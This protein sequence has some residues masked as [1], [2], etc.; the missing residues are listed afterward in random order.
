M[1]KLKC[2]NQAALTIA[3]NPVLHERTNHVE[4]DCHYVKDKVNSGEV[5]TQYVPSYS[6]IADVFTKQLSAAQ[7]KSLVTKLGVKSAAHQA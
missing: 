2:D 5:L 4:I 7:H 6:Q 3:A 1:L